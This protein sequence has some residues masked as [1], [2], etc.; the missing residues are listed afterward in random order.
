[1]GEQ[2]HPTQE[3]KRQKLE[4]S[5]CSLITKGLDSNF[6]T[7]VCALV[8][9]LENLY[10]LRMLDELKTAN[11]NIFYDSGSYSFIG[12][13]ILLNVKDGMNIFAIKM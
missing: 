6:I 9:G 5:I 1:M 12:S 3:V 10:C 11:D 4:Y 13:Q 8:F 2:R 7:E